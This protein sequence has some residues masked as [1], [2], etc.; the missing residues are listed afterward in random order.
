MA[1]A[2]RRPD[3]TGLLHISKTQLTTYLQCPR[4]FWFQYVIGQPWEFAPATLAFGSA[5]HDAVAWFYESVTEGITPSPDH[6]RARFRDRWIRERSRQSLRYFNDQT[7]TGLTGLGDALIEVF[8]G[9]IR[10]R[11]ILAV[12]RSFAVDLRGERDVPL[13]VK[14]IG[15]IDLI[16]EDDEGHAIVCELKTSAKRYSDQQ[17][18]QQ[19]DGLV[20]GYAA[21]QL[22]LSS[23]DG[24]VLVRYD[25]L[26]KAKAPALQ[27]VYVTKTGA[28]GVRLV[29]WIQ[30]IL[31][32]I[33]MEAFYPNYGWACQQCPFQQACQ[34]ISA[35]PIPIPPI[36]APSVPGGSR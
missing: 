31:H 11:R 27:Q 2:D 16:E 21:H 3:W 19:M 23:A 26:I 5:I 8:C 35:T 1:N 24:E 34:R 14:L 7:E 33:E 36:A 20:Y 25:V 32:A 9:E 18:D 6:V 10:P 12:E 28:D 13:D 29:R 15:A 22:G 30:E 17:S 4:R